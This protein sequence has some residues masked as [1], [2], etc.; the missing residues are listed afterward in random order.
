MDE[1]LDAWYGALYAKRNG[2]VQSTRDNNFEYGIW[3]STVEKYVQPA[4]FVYEL[5]QNAEDQ[6]SP[7]ALY[8]TSEGRVVCTGRGR[9]VCTTHGRPMWTTRG[10]V[11]C[12]T[13]VT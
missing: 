4:H 1:S 5:L 6:V 13:F 12:T 11:N 2:W 10:R 9:A 8:C 7:V 3:Q